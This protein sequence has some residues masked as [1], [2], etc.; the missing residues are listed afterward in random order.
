MVLHGVRVQMMLCQVLLLPESVCSKSYRSESI[1]RNEECL[2]ESS[3]VYGFL[4]SSVPG[5]HP[6]RPALLA[7]STHEP[8]RQIPT[9]HEKVH[10]GYIIDGML[11]LSHIL[12]SQNV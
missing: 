6:A 7:P 10:I 11:S 9:W 5:P 3:F 4:A 8:Q 2:M 1:K 12:R